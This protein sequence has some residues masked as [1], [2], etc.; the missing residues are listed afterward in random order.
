MSAI[1][2]IVPIKANLNNFFSDLDRVFETH[3]ISREFYLS[4]DLVENENSIHMHFDIPGVEEKNIQVEYEQGLLKIFG[5]RTDPNLPIAGQDQEDDGENYSRVYK[6]RKFG[7]FSRKFRLPETI[8]ASRIQA[9][10]KNGVLSLVLPKKEKA[11]P[12]K[13]SIQN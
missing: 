6:E 12:L 7:S 4:C 8:D 3:P 11:K 13:I 9:T 1:F 5:E 2:P 10:H